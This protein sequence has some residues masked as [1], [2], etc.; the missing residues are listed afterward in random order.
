MGP[1]YRHL[2]EV[3]EALAG[4]DGIYLRCVVEEYAALLSAYRYEAGARRRSCGMARRLPRLRRLPGFGQHSDGSWFRAYS[5]DGG[6]ITEPDSGSARPKFNRS[7]QPPLPI[8]FLVISTKSTGE[9]RLSLEAARRAGEFVRRHFVERMKFNGGIHDSI[10]A[11]P[12]L[13]DGESIIFAMQALL[14][15]IGRRKAPTIWKARSAPGVSSSLGFASGMCRCRHDLRS[16][17]SDSDRPDGWPAILPARAISIR[18][19]SWLF[20]DLVELGLASGEALFFRLPNCSRP[21][22]TKPSPCRQKRGA[23]PC[24]G[25]RKKDC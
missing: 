25:S 5:P 20:P 9:E 22:A 15:C 2:R 18:W 6:P 1:L 10:Y 3:I 21:A 17:V 7:P 24:L 16:R 12:Q 13:V 8:P 23:M 4:R 14:V 19:A 11:K